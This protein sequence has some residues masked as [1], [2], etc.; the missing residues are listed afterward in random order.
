MT[1]RI[2]KHRRMIILFDWVERI[3]PI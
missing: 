1:I 2:G 3:L